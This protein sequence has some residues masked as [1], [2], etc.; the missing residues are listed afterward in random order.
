MRL[1]TLALLVSIERYGTVSEAARAA[2]ISQPAVSSQI[3][4]LEAELGID[5]FN[6]NCAKN[7]L[8]FTPEGNIALNYAKRLI[9]IENE[10]REHLS[11]AAPGSRILNI[12]TGPTAGTYIAMDLIE[13]FKLEFPN[14]ECI[15]KMG[16]SGNGILEYLEQKQC[17]ILITSV[18]PSGNKFA[19]IPLCEEDLLLVAPH[20]F[21]IP[22]AISA[23]DLKHYPLILREKSSATY[24]VIEKALKKNGVSLRDM[25]VKMELLSTEAI[26]RAV[27]T[28]NGLGFLPSASIEK[29]GMKRPFKIVNLWDMKIT[30]FINLILRKKETYA[31][32]IRGFVDF[33]TNGEW[34]RELTV[35]KEPSPP[36]PGPVNYFM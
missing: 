11:P 8:S 26:I 16:I 17:Q 33:A 5:I 32:L 34:R 2:H 27:E 19:V 30:R 4:Q 21:D 3:K 35:L 15:V 6:R 18:S 36:S 25:R 22:E 14:V 13:R 9:G 29:Q 20:R 7:L 10:M 12:V 23:Q 1:E 31:P 24:S 28:G